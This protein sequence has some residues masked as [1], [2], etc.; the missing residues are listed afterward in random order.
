MLEQRSFEHLLSTFRA[1]ASNPINLSSIGELVAQ[2]GA[3]FIKPC[4]HWSEFVRFGPKIGQHVAN[5]GEKLRSA[6]G[7]PLMT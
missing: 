2:T 6:A 7:K 1:S 3:K 5:L 4:Q